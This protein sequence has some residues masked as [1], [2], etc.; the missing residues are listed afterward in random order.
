MIGLNFTPESFVAPGTLP[1][2]D[3]GAIPL[4]ERQVVLTEVAGGDSNEL[5]SDIVLLDVEP[6]SLGT[7]VHFEFHSDFPNGPPLTPV[8]NIPTVFILETGVGAY[9]LIDITSALNSGALQIIIRNDLGEPEPSPLPASVW[10]GL[11][12]L[13]GLAMWRMVRLLKHACV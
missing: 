1:L 9:Q 8:P 5:Y 13:A 4:G 3:S 11:A 10:S 7:M 12:L 6:S 2:T